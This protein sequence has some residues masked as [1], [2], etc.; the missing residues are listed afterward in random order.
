M[1]HQFVQI[2]QVG[3]NRNGAVDREIGVTKLRTQI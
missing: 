3:G 1:E 2:Q